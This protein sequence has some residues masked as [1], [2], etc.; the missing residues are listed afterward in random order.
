MRPL[1]RPSVLSIAPVK[2]HSAFD[3]SPSPGGSDGSDISSGYLSL[4]EHYERIVS[5]LEDIL[6]LSRPDSVDRKDLLSTDIQQNRLTR[7]FLENILSMLVGWAC[8]IRI[9]YGYLDT[10]RDIA[11]ECLVSAKFDDLETQLGNLW[12]E[13]DAG[14][15]TVCV[16]KLS[17][18]TSRLGEN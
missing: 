12:R 2:S 7:T 8:D 1:S 11:M 9:E 18:Y 10:H 17:P 3:R 4:L 5:S 16:E 6:N 14:T 15:R 13:G